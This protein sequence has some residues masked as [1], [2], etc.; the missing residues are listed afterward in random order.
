[1][2]A[3]HHIRISVTDL[4]DTVLVADY[5]LNVGNG[6]PVVGSSPP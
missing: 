5:I 6:A 1:M 4:R 2:W 3:A